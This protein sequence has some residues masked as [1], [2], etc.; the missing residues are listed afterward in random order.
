MVEPWVNIYT[1]DVASN[2]CLTQVQS[3]LS[4]RSNVNVVQSF[5][6]NEAQMFIDFLDQVSHLHLPLIIT[7]SKG[8]R[9]LN[10]RISTKNTD[11]GA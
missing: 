4:C 2:E 1:M 9:F 5:R 3:L 7:N 6:G 11:S 8:H 10:Y